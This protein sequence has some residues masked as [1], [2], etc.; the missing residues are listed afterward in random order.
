[1]GASQTQRSFNLSQIVISSRNKITKSFFFFR[2][3]LCAAIKH[4][5]SF[6]VKKKRKKK[7]CNR[8]GHINKIPVM[9]VCPTVP[10]RLNP[11]GPKSAYTHTPVHLSCTSEK[12]WF[13][14]LLPFSTDFFLKALICQQKWFT[15]K[16]RKPEKTQHA[17]YLALGSATLLK[18]AFL[19]ESDPNFAWTG[20]DVAQWLQCARIPIRRPWVRSPGEAGW[21]T[22]DLF[23]SPRVNSCADVFVP[24]LPFV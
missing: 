9:T 4:K 23:L 6:C 1:M 19:G 16:M 20:T 15:N 8:G 13:L 2:V 12:N 14:I 3:F 5:K 21:Q 10:P 7:Q 17:L 18:L 24:R 22:D 11:L